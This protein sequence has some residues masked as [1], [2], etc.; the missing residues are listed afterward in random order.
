MSA[1]D[2]STGARQV[3]NMVDVA[4]KARQKTAEVV[5]VAV[6]VDASAPREVVGWVRDALVPERDSALVDVELVPETGIVRVHSGSTLAIVVAG[7]LTV[8]GANLFSGLI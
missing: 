1:F 6:Y 4:K 7:L 5:H 8:V 2:F 3:F